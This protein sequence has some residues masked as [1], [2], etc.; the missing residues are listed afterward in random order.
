[1]PTAVESV[2]PETNLRIVSTLY[3]IENGLRELIIELFQGLNDP[4]WYKHRLPPDLFDKYKQGRTHERSQAW[5]QCVP[6]HP[7]YYLDFP[8]IATILERSD[9]WEQ[10]FKA[11]FCRKDITISGLRR[12]EPIRNTVAHNRKA[13]AADLAI[14]EAQYAELCS[15]LGRDRLRELANRCTC[16]VDIPT[17]LCGLAEEVRRSFVACKALEPLPSL[18]EWNSAIKQWW[19]DPEYLGCDVDP[20]AKYFNAIQQYAALPWRRGSGPEIERW[21]AQQIWMRSIARRKLRSSVYSGAIDEYRYRLGQA[22]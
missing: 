16:E 2:I 13:S 22:L 12:L 10:V 4:R 11:V 3:V 17:R 21:Y 9:N 19:F 20:I 6:H 5:T 14:V 18:D 8:D 1:M 7:V 15:P